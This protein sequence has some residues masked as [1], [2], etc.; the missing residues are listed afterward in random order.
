MDG[1]LEVRR[2]DMKI[3]SAI[4]IAILMAGCGSSVTGTNT[5]LDV[6]HKGAPDC[7]QSGCH[8]G[9]GAGGTVFASLSSTTTVSG[10]TVKATDVSNLE[11]TTVGTTDTLGNFHY[12]NSLSG[13]FQMTVGSRQS[14]IYLHKLPDDNGC[15]GCHK[16]PTPGGGAQGKLY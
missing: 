4:F 14:G 16:W 15:N 5:A 8:P 12:K 13:N 10:V 3:L 7:A 9:L 11:T 1:V 2:G 6:T